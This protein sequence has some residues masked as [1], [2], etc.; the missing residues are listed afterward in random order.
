[1]RTPIIAGNWKL[2]KKSSDA[3]DF[4]TRLTAPAVFMPLSA[5]VPLVSTLNSWSAS[6]KGN[7]T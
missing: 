4:V 7:A 2:F 5:D 1:M 6:G 3:V